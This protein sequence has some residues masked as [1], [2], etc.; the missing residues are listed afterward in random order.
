MSN[1]FSNGSRHSELDISQRCGHKPHSQFSGN[2]SSGVPKHVSMASSKRSRSLPPFFRHSQLWLGNHSPPSSHTQ[3]NRDFSPLQSLELSSNSNINSNVHEAFQVFETSGSQSQFLKSLQLPSDLCRHSQISRDL[4]FLPKH[5]DRVHA[6]CSDVLFSLPDPGPLSE[7]PTDHLTLCQSDCSPRIGL[8]RSVSLPTDL[9]VFNHRL[10]SSLRS[11]RTPCRLLQSANP[12]SRLAKNPLH[13]IIPAEPLCN[14]AGLLGP[15]PLSSHP[16]RSAP[17]SSKPKPKLRSGHLS[18][19]SSSKK[20]FPSPQEKRLSNHPH[21]KCPFRTFSRP[22][23]CRCPGLIQNSGLLGTPP[24]DVSSTTTA[25]SPGSSS[26]LQRPVHLHKGS[27][28]SQ[29]IRP[30]RFCSHSKQQT[31]VQLG[32]AQRLGQS[33][34]LRSFERSNPSQGVLRVLPQPLS[35]VE[36]PLL[37]TLAKIPYPFFPCAFDFGS[38]S[39]SSE[40]EVS[41][42]SPHSLLGLSQTIQGP[43]SSR[44][45]SSLP[46]RRSSSASSPM[47]PKPR[48]LPS[49]ERS[50]LGPHPSISTHH[51]LAATS[52][53]EPSAQSKNN[54]PTPLIDSN[55]PLCRPSD[56]RPT[57][58]TADPRRLP[59]QS[60]SRPIRPVLVSGPLPGQLLNPVSSLSTPIRNLKSA[61]GSPK[62]IL[63][64]S[65]SSYYNSASS[66]GFTTNHRRK[67][68]LFSKAFNNL[69]SSMLKHPFYYSSDSSSE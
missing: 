56:L 21:P 17:K 57:P 18:R 59:H 8:H 36:A 58:S 66:G 35:E 34:N 64:P 23:Q 43:V 3:S 39:S 44:R 41:N 61:A 62:T 49:K 14:Q 69:S 27:S 53:S 31:R 42:P 46:Q 37:P 60:P 29:N 24:G 47:G 48:L 40:P 50:V 54:P 19:D 12:R 67:F 52:T 28:H 55:V 65:D 7:V 16:E 26:S 68:S 5:S 15:C 4:P 63:H 10:N 51:S 9:S 20:S 1:V 22:V 32:H 30:S 13:S 33:S 38:F 11:R 2:S 45:S 6:R 25:P